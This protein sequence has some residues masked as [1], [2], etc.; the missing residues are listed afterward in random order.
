MKSLDL[1]LLLR[2][3]ALLKKCYGSFNGGN[4]VFILDPCILNSDEQ[5]IRLSGTPE[6]KCLERIIMDVIGCT[7]DRSVT[8]N[9]LVI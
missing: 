1:T 7:W 3:C 9:G 2:S 4:W 8:V 6:K 5:G